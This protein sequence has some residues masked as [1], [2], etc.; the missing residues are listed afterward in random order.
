MFWMP[1]LPRPGVC[2][3]SS[4]SGACLFILFVVSV[5]EQ[6]LRFT[7]VQPR[8]FP[9]MGAAFGVNSKKPLP[10]HSLSFL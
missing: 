8:D 6:M 2:K 3:Y 1:L 4:R 5:A 7:K 10:S 9:F